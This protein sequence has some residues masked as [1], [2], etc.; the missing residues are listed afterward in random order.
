MVEELFHQSFI[1]LDS[2]LNEERTSV[3]GFFKHVGRNLTHGQFV[4]SIILVGVGLHINEVNHTTDVF[5]KTDWQMNRY[6]VLGKTFM[7]RVEG[8][9]EVATDL[10]DLVDET[11][12]RHAVFGR[13]AQTVSD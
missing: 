3:L 9:I 12:A 13:L 6:S 10:V 7:N 5:F 1:G 4:V 2:F 11:D 8:F